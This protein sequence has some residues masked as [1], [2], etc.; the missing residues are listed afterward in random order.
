M[1][2]VMR[3]VE[4]PGASTITTTMLGAF[5]EDKDLRKEFLNLVNKP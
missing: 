1:C 4:K 5:E 3:G 2:M